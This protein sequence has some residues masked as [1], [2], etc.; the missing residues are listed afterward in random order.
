MR[1]NENEMEFE[2]VGRSGRDEGDGGDEG[3][4]NGGDWD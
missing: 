3:G 2:E 1:I 4:E